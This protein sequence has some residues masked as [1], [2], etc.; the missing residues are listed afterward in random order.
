MVSSR[1]T[2]SREKTTLPTTR[3]T[4]ATHWQAGFDLRRKRF[5]IPEEP[6]LVVLPQ[7]GIRGQNVHNHIGADHETCACNGDFGSGELLLVHT[8]EL[9][10]ELG[11]P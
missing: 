2:Y 5:K 7:S 9:N 6:D 8:D 3:I 11:Q 10:P 4:P 1:S